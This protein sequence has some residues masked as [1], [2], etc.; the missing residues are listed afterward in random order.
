MSDDPEVATVDAALAAVDED[1]HYRSGQLLTYLGNK[2]ALRTQIDHAAQV[3]QSRL[4]RKLVILDAFSGSGS[5]S[6]LLKARAASIVANDLESYARVMSECFLA[7]RSDVDTDHLATIVDELNTVVD[8]GYSVD[9]FVEE[10]YAP[11]DD[12]HIRAGE[13][14]FYTRDNARRLDAYI[15]LIGRQEPAVRPLLLGPLLSRA[16]V[17]AN[18]SGIFKGFH[19]DK[20]TGIGRFGGSGQDALLRILGTIR[21]EPPVLSRHHAEATV[22]QM[23]ANDLPE[24]LGPVDLAYLDPPYNQHPY[25][26]NYF[27]LNLLTDYRR[28]TAISPV[29]GIP[30]DWN[31]SRYNVRRESADLMRDL[32]GSLDA[33]FLLVSFS[34]DGFIAPEEMIDILRSVGELT[35]FRFRY[36]TFRGCRNLRDR[37]S[38]VTEHLYLVE[39]F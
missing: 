24:H 23:D 10:L 9:G 13:R 29:S 11:D 31:R 36:N 21:L 38:H 32:A 15:T 12:H 16:S 17:H 4:G 27:M 37:S 39:K 14:V 20:L 22:L 5:V 25:G 26:S 33:R 6:R 18:T 2:R 34:D 3:V 35:E 7:N 1:P 28:P 19:K 30:T 8:Q